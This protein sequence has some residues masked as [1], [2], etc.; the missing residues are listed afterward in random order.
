MMKRENGLS[1]LGPPGFEASLMLAR[2]RNKKR[3]T[4]QKMQ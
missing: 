2:V 1:I 3:T 4:Q